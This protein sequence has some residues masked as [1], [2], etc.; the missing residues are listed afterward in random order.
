MTRL[1]KA[2]RAMTAAT[3]GAN[4]AKYFA[5]CSRRRA[6]QVVSTI[7]SATVCLVDPPRTVSP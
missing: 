3:K 7:I 1:E 6:C 4:P 2:E 5:P